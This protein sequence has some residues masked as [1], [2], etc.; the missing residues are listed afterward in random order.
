MNKSW[1]KVS[2]KAN[3]QTSRSRRSVSLRSPS[4]PTATSNTPRIDQPRDD[5]SIIR[6]FSL[7]DTSITDHVL[8][9]YISSNNGSDKFSHFGSDKKELEWVLRASPSTLKDDHI[10]VIVI[11]AIINYEIFG[12]I[13]DGYF[14]PSPPRRAGEREQG[15]IYQTPRSSEYSVYWTNPRLSSNRPQ[16]KNKLLPILNNNPIPPSPRRSHR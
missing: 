5:A 12:A 9:Y 7:I 3:S 15:M 2:L 4:S 13:Q 14:I 6:L 8:N 11:R 10:Q 1:W 16:P